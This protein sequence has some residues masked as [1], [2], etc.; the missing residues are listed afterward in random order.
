V[1]EALGLTWGDVD[2]DAKTIM[3]SKQLST[4]GERVPTKTTAS[5]AP[6]PLLPALERELRTHRSRQAGRDLRFTHRD[7]LLLAPPVASRSP[8][9]TPSGQCS[10]PV[11]RWG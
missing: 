7:A 2:L 9:A 11:T 10:T 6:V 4:S 8:A 5:R 1:S 3:V